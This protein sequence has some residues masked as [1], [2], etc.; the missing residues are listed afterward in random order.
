MSD[1]TVELGS[2]EV[3]QAEAIADEQLSEL[4]NNETEDS[5]QESVE[6]AVEQ[7]SIDDLMG[8]TK[9]QDDEQHKKNN[10]YA[11][12]RIM[13]KKLKQ[14][15]QAVEQG[16]LPEDYAYKP[17]GD[18]SEPDLKDFQGRLYDDYEGDTSLMLAHYQDSIRKFEQHRSSDK[19]AREQHNEQVLKNVQAQKAN[20][21][22]FIASIDKHKAIVPNLDQ[23]LIRA[24]EKLGVN[25]FEAVKNAIGNENAPLVLGVI[26]TNDKVF[27]DLVQ[28]AQNGQ[29]SIIQYL[30]RL[31]DKIK[32]NL[33][34]KNTVSKA[35]SESPLSGGNSSVIDYDAEISKVFKDPKMRGMK[36]INRI[37][38]LRKAKASLAV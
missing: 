4:G 22:A 36:G 31:E 15:E 3:E 34:S 18:V 29:L 10:L 37:K 11:Q 33:S 13:S 12:N 32:N 1:S 6:E 21:E 30:T 26:G 9:A 35:A 19:Q 14:L 7:V 20:D 24:E 25:D 5:T 28:A 16:K 2:Q 23:S 38:E 17:Q 8:E 27:D